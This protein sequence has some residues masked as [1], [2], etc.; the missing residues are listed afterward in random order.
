MI[1]SN[2]KFII[3]NAIGFTSPEYSSDDH[4]VYVNVTS[5]TFPMGTFGIV[6]NVMLKKVTPE[7]VNEETQEVISPEVINWE[8]ISQF[9]VPNEMVN[10]PDLDVITEASNITKALLE[11]W[12]PENTFTVEL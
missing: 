8:T 12:N 4:K 7:V 10:T 9:S 2:K 11:E 5:N 3:K 6:G 1:K